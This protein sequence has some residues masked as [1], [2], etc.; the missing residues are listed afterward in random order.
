MYSYYLRL[1]I[2][3]LRKNPVLTALM[4]G[5]IAIG[6]GVSMTTLTVYHIMSSNPIPQKSDDLH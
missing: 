2:H 6:I 5:A 1:A 3:S 4:I